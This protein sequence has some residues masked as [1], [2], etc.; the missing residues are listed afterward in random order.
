MEIR[1]SLSRRLNRTGFRYGE[2]DPTDGVGGLF[3]Q[4]G[5]F[6]FAD[7]Q[8]YLDSRR[9]VGAEALD[10]PVTIVSINPHSG[11]PIHY[12][13]NQV[14][15]LKLWARTVC[16]EEALHASKV[17]HDFPSRLKRLDHYKVVALDEGKEMRL[18]GIVF[19]CRGPLPPRAFP[20]EICNWG[21]N[22]E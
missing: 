8:A 17:P 7:E 2:L 4:G 9:Q 19:N 14:P 16:L 20:R 6:A 1:I 15:L 13:E 3:S 22:A 12:N 21:L 5:E 18:D 10:E 11:A